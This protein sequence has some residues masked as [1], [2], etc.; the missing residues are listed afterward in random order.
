MNGVATGFRFP[1]SKV[2]LTAAAVAAFIFFWVN[3]PLSERPPVFEFE[4]H[5]TG[6]GEPVRV[7]EEFIPPKFGVIGDEE[8]NPYYHTMTAKEDQPPTYAIIGDARTNPGLAAEVA[9]RVLEN[10]K[11]L[12][13]NPDNVS[14][15]TALD[16]YYTEERDADGRV[17]QLYFEN[18]G[19]NKNIK[20][21]SGPI[22]IG[23]AVGID[24]TIRSVSHVFS[25]ETT[26][27]L[28]DIEKKGFYEQFQSLPLDD[29]TYEIDIVSG[30]SLTTEGIA[31]SVSDL[32][33]IARESP[34]EIY[35]DTQAAGFETKPVLPSTW[36]VDAAMI[37]VLFVITFLR[38][39]RRSPNL[40]L[41]FGLVT[42]AYLGFWQNNSFTYATFT[43]PFLGI[44]WSYILGIYAALVL[45]SAIWDNNSYCRYICP[46]GNVQ[47]MLMRLI[48]WHSKLK[49]S[50]RL[51]A[52]I[53]WGI[54]IALVI[55][56]FAGLRDWG[57]YELFPDLFGLEF[58]SSQWFWLSVAAVLVSAYYPMLW[59][60]ML[61]PTGA[62]LDGITFVAKSR[63][64][65][66]VNRSA[67]R[68]SPVVVEQTAG[69]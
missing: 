50:N 41:I 56:I 57:S 14:L 62:I 12:A 38:V 39:T 40:A 35:I 6:F 55:G 5:V 64:A 33:S 18:T 9:E 51:L 37:G 43:Q 46:Y 24:G 69:A 34:L 36:I 16:L 68:P 22:D 2:S 59:C 21:Y 49:I 65:K 61:C 3:G 7:G 8:R 44:S 28:Q 53:R 19:L 17:V 67:V 13:A 58:M 30:A 25:M 52:V 32:V 60:R 66:S 10:G 63:A 11:S 15:R 27:Y 42:I 54:T 20:G 47:R 31:R 26:S 45:I 1:W 29:K 4:E 48:P 23:M